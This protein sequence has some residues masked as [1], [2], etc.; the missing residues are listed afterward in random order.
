MFDEG[1]GYFRGNG[2]IISFLLL[3]KTNTKSVGEFDP[4]NTNNDYIMG[5]ATKVKGYN[6][7]KTFNGGALTNPKG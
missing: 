3:D 4:L 1:K 6:P 7:T 2:F 5:T